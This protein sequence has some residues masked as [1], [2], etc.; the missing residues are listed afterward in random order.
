[1][2]WKVEKMFVGQAVEIKEY[3]WKK[4]AWKKYAW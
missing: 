3:A 2:D 1:M 4:Y